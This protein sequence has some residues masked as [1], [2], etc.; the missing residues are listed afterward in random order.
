MNIKQ[1]IFYINSIKS[2][3]TND[4]IDTIGNELF[5]K[6]VT[7]GF[8]NKGLTTWKITKLGEYQADFYRQPNEEEKKLGILYHNL[9]I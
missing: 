7:L 1:A 3:Y 8:I 4:L 6:F 5:D 2:G 9:G